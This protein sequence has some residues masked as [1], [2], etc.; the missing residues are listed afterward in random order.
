MATKRAP[1]K[2]SLYFFLLAGFAWSAEASCG[3]KPT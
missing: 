1:F 2:A 3:S